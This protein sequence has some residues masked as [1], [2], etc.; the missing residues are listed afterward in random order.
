[1]IS[2]DG[3]GVFGDVRASHQ[4]GQSP[5]PRAI[6]TYSFPAHPIA[7]WADFVARI[8]A[9]P[10]VVPSGGGAFLISDYTER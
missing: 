1:M 6:S 7:K 8:K 5:L 3:N 2:I 9:P 10:P 4:R